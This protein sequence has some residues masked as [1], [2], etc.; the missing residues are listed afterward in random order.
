MTLQ[1]TAIAFFTAHDDSYIGTEAA[2]G[3]WSAQH[4]HA[5]PVLALIARAI[6]ALHEPDQLLTRLS[7][8]LIAPVPMAGVRVQACRQRGGRSV[9]T[10]TAEVTD[11]AGKV[12]ASASAMLIGQRAIGPVPTAGGL[13]LPRADARHDRFP[14]RE[15][16]HGLPCFSDHVAVML[17]SGE[18]A[19]P[20]PTMIWMKTPA[21]IEGETP[22]AF[23]R[24]CPLADCGNGI[25]RNAGLD[26]YSFINADITIVRHRVTDAEWLGSAARSHW[27]SSGIGLASAELFD[28]DGPIASVLQTLIVRPASG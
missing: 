13:P 1:S 6:E 26:R 21:I 24:L 14:I 3:P 28:D 20:G 11:L 12:C 5:G 16:A 17:P 2:R 18:T 27:Q 7:V 23:Q 19:D 10:A 4:C 15:T 25:S 8:D 9:S 22:S